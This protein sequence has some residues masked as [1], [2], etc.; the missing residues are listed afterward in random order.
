M[1]R[2]HEIHTFIEQCENVLVSFRSC[3]N[4]AKGFTKCCVKNKATNLRYDILESTFEKIKILSLQ[5]RLR[6]VLFKIV[7]II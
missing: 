5:L 1:K 7:T 6:V 3:K 4:V 2:N